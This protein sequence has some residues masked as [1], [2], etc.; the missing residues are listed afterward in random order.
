MVPVL[1]LGERAAENQ[2]AEASLDDADGLQAGAID[3]GGGDGQVVADGPV[4]DWQD[5][6][7]CGVDSA[8]DL[9]GERAAGDCRARRVAAA[10][11]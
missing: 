1:V 8:E 10:L 5:P 11:R 6:C 4:V 7:A 3:D 9:Q 2:R